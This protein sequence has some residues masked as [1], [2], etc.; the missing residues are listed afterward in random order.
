M[1]LVYNEKVVL[2]GQE[3]T[4]KGR[5]QTT[6]NNPMSQDQALAI[7]RQ[8]IGSTDPDVTSMFFSSAHNDLN[9]LP[10]GTNSRVPLEAGVGGMSSWE[11]LLY[12]KIEEVKAK[13]LRSE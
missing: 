4:H 1:L 7:R 11:P 3:S 13:R 5:P 10:F 9:F 2:P 6:G 12:P 8:L